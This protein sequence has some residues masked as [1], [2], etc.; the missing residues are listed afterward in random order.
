[1]A[2]ASKRVADAGRRAIDR[3]AA[4]SRLETDDFFEP[5]T[6]VR[7]LFA[8]LVN[9]TDPDGVAIVPSVSYAMATVA[10]NT[11]L[12]AGRTVIVVE[13]QFPSAVYTWRRACREAAGG[14]DA[15]SAS[16]R[17]GS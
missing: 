12:A 1:M 5:A 6:R 8:R 9:A 13:E 17:R 16:G 14:P 4:P 10:R 11:P 2:P 15:A 7:G 3:I